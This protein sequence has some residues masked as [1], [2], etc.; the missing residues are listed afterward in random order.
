MEIISTMDYVILHYITSIYINIAAIIWN[1]NQCIVPETVDY[2]VT[3][4]II[5]TCCYVL[6]FV[7]ITL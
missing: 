4:I 1:F 6:L 5:Y 3:Y 2:D 7:T